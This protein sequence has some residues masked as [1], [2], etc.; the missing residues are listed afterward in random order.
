MKNKVKNLIQITFSLLGLTLVAGASSFANDTP[1]TCA[2][3]E[4]M[5]KARIPVFV[6]HE[7][8]RAEEPAKWFKWSQL[9]TAY[10]IMHHQNL[11]REYAED[12]FEK[13]QFYR[14]QIGNQTFQVAD[15]DLGDNGFVY[16]FYPG[17]TRWTGVSIMDGEVIANNES[18]SSVELP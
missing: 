1:L 2:T 10:R 4:K 13:A 12:I 5:Q 7:Y 6:R 3:L 18:C 14:Y 17:T 9:K 16:L 8:S 15:M 11:P